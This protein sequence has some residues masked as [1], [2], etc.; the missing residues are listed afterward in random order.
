MLVYDTLCYVSWL[1]ASKAV[2]QGTIQWSS[3][4][5]QKV[6]NTLHYFQTHSQDQVCGCSC[7]TRSLQQLHTVICH[8]REQRFSHL[9]GKDSACCPTWHGSGCETAAGCEVQVSACMA[10]AQVDYI[11]SGFAPLNQ[12]HL[13]LQDTPCPDARQICPGVS[14]HSASLLS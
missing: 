3:N 1:H 4:E 2:L 12:K 13:F 8:R 7:A 10:S 14:L 6:A 5:Q 11:L 9:Q